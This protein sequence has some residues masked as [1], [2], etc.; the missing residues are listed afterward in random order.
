MKKLFLFTVTVLSL[1][2]FVLSA[3]A[4]TELPA[5]DETEAAD[6]LGRWYLS[7][8]CDKDSC[9]N[10]PEIGI[11]MTYDFNADNK[12]IINTDT[13]ET[14]ENT[15]Y[16]ENGKAYTNVY[17]TEDKFVVNDMSINE[18]GLL[19]TANEDSYA[20]YTREEPAPVVAPE[21]VA[22]AI[23]ENFAGEWHIKGLMIEN[24]LIPSTVFGS[25]NL[26]TIGENTFVMSTEGNVKETA[27]SFDAGKITAV[28][29]DTDSEGNVLKDDVLIEY[30]EDGTL[31]FRLNPDTETETIMV[32][33]R[34]QTVTETSSTAEPASDTTGSDTTGGSFIITLLKQLMNGKDMNIN[35]LLQQLTGNENTDI[36]SLV[37]GLLSGQ[38]GSVDLNGILDKLTSGSSSEAGGVGLNDLLNLFGSGK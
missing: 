3:A 31:Y 25:D 32:F 33:S 29:E 26:L 15:W 6:Y 38:E 2:I 12:V 20:T 37:S 4:Q 9:I 1:A 10:F 19:V 7:D 36:N 24:Q 22:D 17:L 18:N 13:N 23:P 16:M 5:I 34:E 27:Y 35:G 11:L 28:F 21:T 8:I 14:S 30:H